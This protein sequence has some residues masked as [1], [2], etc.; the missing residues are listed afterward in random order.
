MAALFALG[1]MSLGWMAFIAALIAVEKLLPWKA[2]ANRGIAVLL[3]ALGLAVAFTPASV[4][5]SPS[6]GS[7]EAMHAHGRRLDERRLDERRL[8]ERGLDGRRLDERG[9]DGRR[10]DGQRLD[11]RGIDGRRLDGQPDGRRPAPPIRSPRGPGSRLRSSGPDQSK[12][13]C[14]LERPGQLHLN[15]N[16]STSSS[17]A[18]AQVAT[19]PG[20]TS[21]PGALWTCTRAPS[22]LVGPV[23]ASALPLALPGT[24]TRQRPRSSAISNSIGAYSI[25]RTSSISSAKP[26]GQPPASPAEDRLQRLALALVGA[27][28]DEEPHRRLGLAG[29]DVALERADRDHVQAVER[30]V[31]IVALAD[32]P[33]E[34][35]VAL[36]LVRGLGERAAAR[37]PAPADV[38]PVAGESPLRNLGHR[39]LL[40]SLDSHRPTASN[41]F[42]ALPRRAVPQYLSGVSL[43]V[44]LAVDEDER[45]L[46]D[47]ER[48]LADRYSRS[49]RVVCV[50]SAEEAMA[51]LEA[52]AAAGEDVA[53]VLAA[54]SLE[55]DERG[56]SCWAGCGISTRTPSAGC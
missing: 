25:P 23:S 13:K 16:A 21:A 19:W 4:P 45:S 43:P 28:V 2:L 31:A 26:A 20:P 22:G 39:F 32:V 7:P 33:G 53:L 5:A 15:P 1:V 55:R 6:P 41:Q 24:S 47:V 18:V 54:Q 35:A 42:Q 8:D 3:L 40:R 34:D 38:E 48:E 56:A 27:L 12:G 49:Y 10:V 36:A 9:L 46:R 17:V 52:L 37:H 30:H 51:E 50:S 14:L 11:E 29:P 44:L